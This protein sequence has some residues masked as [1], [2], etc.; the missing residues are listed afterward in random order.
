VV[1]VYPKDK[2]E[3]IIWLYFV[4]TKI[5]ET[6]LLDYFAGLFSSTFPRLGWCHTFF[7]MLPPESRMT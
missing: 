2:R 3:N 6:N 7:K 5:P 1:P 4:E